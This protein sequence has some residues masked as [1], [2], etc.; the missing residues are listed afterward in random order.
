M[1]IIGGTNQAAKMPDVVAN[2]RVDQGWGSAQIMGAL[3]EVRKM[4]S[5]R[6]AKE[7][8]GW[9]IGAGVQVNLP[10]LAEGDNFG[11]QTAYSE[12]YLAAHGPYMSSPGPL[13]EARYSAARNK[14]DLAQ[15]WSAVAG[16]QH[17]W[18]PQISST[19]AIGYVSVWN[20]GKANNYD[21]W[22]FQGGIAYTPVAGMH[23]G[24]EL[25]YRLAE[26]ASNRIDNEDSLV[27]M[28]RLQRDF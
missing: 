10:M 20:L 7:E 3:H 24:G 21:N 12:G 2:L 8:M 14:L 15:A 5:G 23:I 4:G 17:F 18:T 25:A 28:I 27:G 13:A 11:I 19:F 16:F 1:G 6:R 22:D 9:G 26:P